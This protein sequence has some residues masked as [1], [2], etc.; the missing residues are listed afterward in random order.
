MTN[1]T[2]PET[3]ASEIAER[4][5]VDL[6]ALRQRV[7]QLDRRVTALQLLSAADDGRHIEQA[8]MDTAAAATDLHKVTELLGGRGMIDRLHERVVSLGDPT[9]AR[10][11]DALVDE[12]DEIRARVGRSSMLTTAA[13]AQLEQQ[14]ALILGRPAVSGEYRSSPNSPAG[15]GASPRLVDR[16][17]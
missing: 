6:M 9:F 2:L 16:L 3:A 11:L 8:I 10:T 1:A 13:S 12:I 5:R 7:C 17:A 15:Y 4:L 14:I